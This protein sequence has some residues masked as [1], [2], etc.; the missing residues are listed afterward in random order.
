MQLHFCSSPLFVN[1]K[2]NI[3][4]YTYLGRENFAIGTWIRNNWD[5]KYTITENRASSNW[6]NAIY[7]HKPLHVRNFVACCMLQ[8]QLQVASYSHAVMCN[9]ATKLLVAQLSCRCK[10][11]LSNTVQLTWYFVSRCR[12]DEQ[13]RLVI[14]L[15]RILAIDPS[16]FMSV[17]E[18]TRIRVQNSVCQ[19]HSEASK[20]SQDSYSHLCSVAG[21]S[22]HRRAICLPSQ[23]VPNCSHCLLV[24]LTRLLVIFSH[25][26]N[27]QARFTS[28]GHLRLLVESLDTNN[29]PVLTSDPCLF[30]EAVL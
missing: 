29:D 25:D 26:R 20:G 6:Q 27:A 18:N 8:L 13:N 3:W 22:P 11:T 23:R 17:F 9:F 10:A 21:V 19:Y 30:S 4:K 16:L 12:M 2:I 5:Q 15:Q 24:L 14:P 7:R 28:G 1:L